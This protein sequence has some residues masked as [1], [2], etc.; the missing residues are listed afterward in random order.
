MDMNSLNNCGQINSFIIQDI[1]HDI[2]SISNVYLA[3]G[4]IID[5]EGNKSPHMFVYIKPKDYDG[6]EPLIIDGAM[7][8]FTD[9][10]KDDG[11]VNSSF[12]SNF[13][14]IL[15]CKLSQSPYN[16]TCTKLMDV[17]N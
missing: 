17:V 16:H 12:G 11:L 13:E 2:D 3:Q 1:H 4:H 15:V 14:T 5:N 8:Q 7:D 9:K 6:N 10:N